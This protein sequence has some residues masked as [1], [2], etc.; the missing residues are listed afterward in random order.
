MTTSKSI[1]GNSYIYTYTSGM[2]GQVSFTEKK[3]NWEILEGPAKGFKGYDDYDIKEVDNGMYFVR[4]HEPK[5]GITVTVLINEQ[6]K[7]VYGSVV[8]PEGLEFDDAEIN[9]MTID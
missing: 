5:N 6:T 3:A 7:K 4:W 2:K 8:S 9:E 1:I